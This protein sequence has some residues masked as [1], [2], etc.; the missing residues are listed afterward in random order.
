MG[1]WRDMN[2]DGL[3]DLISARA[4]SELLTGSF[5]GNQ[6]VVICLKL[7]VIRIS[8]RVAPQKTT[9]MAENFQNQQVT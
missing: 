5:K 7:K 3:M 1:Y 6:I 4:K 9:L 2:G 8:L